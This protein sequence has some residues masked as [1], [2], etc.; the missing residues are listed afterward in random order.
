VFGY[1][2]LRGATARIQPALYPRQIPAVTHA[3]IT[4]GQ[5]QHRDLVARRIPIERDDHLEHNWLTFGSGTPQ[6]RPRRQRRR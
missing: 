1:T 6:S 4:I 5:A 2:S 3:A